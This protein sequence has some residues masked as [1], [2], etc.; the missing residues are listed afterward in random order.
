MVRF[1][2]GPMNGTGNTILMS[3]MS[4]DHQSLAALAWLV[5]AGADEAIGEAP[6]NRFQAKAST[7]ISPSP[8]VGEGNSNA[9]RSNWEG[10]SQRAQKPPPPSSF[11]ARPLPRGEGENVAA[12]FETKKSP[13]ASVTPTSVLNPPTS[14]NDNIGR[15]LEIA[16]ACTSLAELKAALEV[17]E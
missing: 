5:E 10:D 1:F 17:F 6:V 13:R 14:D 2:S 3:S 12:R 9:S 8:L 16:N 7:Q 4:S 11:A 15:A